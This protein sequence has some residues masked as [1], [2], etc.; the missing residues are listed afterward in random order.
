MQ[1]KA[2]ESADFYSLARSERIT[3]QVEQ[4]LD[5][6]FYILCRQVLLLARDNFYELRFGHLS[7]RFLVLGP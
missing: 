5:S 7:L 6:Q 1:R 3:H 4:M 2:A